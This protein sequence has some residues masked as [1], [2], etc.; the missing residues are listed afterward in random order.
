MQDDFDAGGD[1][2]EHDQYLDNDDT[3]SALTGDEGGF[4]PESEDEW[5]QE[6]FDPDFEEDL[7]EGGRR[8][9]DF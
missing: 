8:L 1:E 5:D 2:P 3:P 4:A 6:E 7:D 9:D